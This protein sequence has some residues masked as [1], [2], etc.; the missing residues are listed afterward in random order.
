MEKQQQDENKE[1][2]MKRKRKKRRK[3]RK[4]K[5]GSLLPWKHQGTYSDPRAATAA[6]SS[7]W[8][9]Q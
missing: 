9:P 4:K 8:L 6:L 3:R 5:Q 2:K 1:R 7:D